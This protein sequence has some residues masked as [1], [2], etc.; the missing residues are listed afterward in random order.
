M[1]KEVPDASR[2]PWKNVGYAASNSGP[3]SGI[4]VVDLSRLVAGN[5]ASLQLA[6]SGADVTKIEPLPAGDPLRAWQQDGIQTFWSVYCRNKTSIAL[7]FRHEKSI[8]ILTRL[9]DQA[10]IMIESFR[11][12]ILE[13][14]G[15]AP[16]ILHQR[17]P[18]LIILR[19]SGFGQSGPYSHRPGFGTLVE[20]MSGF[21]SR[22]GEAGGG[23]LLPPVA[24]ADMI[25]GLYGSNGIMMALRGREQTGHGQVID[26]A[27]LDSMVSAIGPDAFDY[28]VTGEVKQRVGNGSN[29]ASPRNIYQTSDDHFIAISA[30]IQSTA[31]RLFATVGAAAMIDDPKFA[32]N[33]ARVK[34]Q[35]EIDI[36]VGGWIA[37]RSRKE[38][39]AIFD[40]EGI[41]A[42]PVNNIADNANDPHFIERGIYVAATNPATDAAMG[43][44]PMHQPLPIME[45]N[46]DRLRM[47]APTLGQHSRAELAKAGFQDNEI[48]QLIALNV[49]SQP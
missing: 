19:V 43:K 37:A 36:V 20:A 3:L 44:V 5:M 31:K 24:L 9:I 40:A 25:S 12:G 38:V 48:D 26:L 17:N 14:M 39:L 8:D 16:A 13:S 10:D 49:I 32:T 45:N 6:D 42:A 41:T 15:L 33:A 7:N 1:K 4:R 35:A 30:S 46:L 18:G 27:L 34:H 2:Q 22:T 28:A 29:T 11:P 47:P 21:A 23:P